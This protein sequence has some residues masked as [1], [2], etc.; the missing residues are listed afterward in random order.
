[1]Y[2]GPRDYRVHRPRDETNTSIKFR[3]R[4]AHPKIY[5]SPDAHSSFI[6]NHVESLLDKFDTVKPSQPGCAICII[7]DITK[8]WEDA[9][10]KHMDLNAIFFT[11]TR[12]IRQ[13]EPSHPWIWSEML[14]SHEQRDEENRQWRCVDGLYSSHDGL[15]TA[16]SYYRIRSNICALW[17]ALGCGNL[18]MITDLFVVDSPP[19]KSAPATEKGDER[20][21][22]GRNRAYL[23]MAYSTD[24]V[25]LLVPS[26][27]DSK[28]AAMNTFD[29]LQKA[30]EY[31]WPRDCL[32]IGAPTHGSHP[33]AVRPHPL[34]YVLSDFAWAHN[35]RHLDAQVKAM[36]FENMQSP[37]RDTATKMLGLRDDLNFLRAEVG[38]ML[39]YTPPNLVRYF[40]AE[41]A[42]NDSWYRPNETPVNSSQRIADD[43]KALEKF[44]TSSLELLMMSIALGDS[45][46][47]ERDSKRAD[48]LTWLAAVYV[49]LSFVT[50]IFGMNLRELNGSSLP[51]WICL[52]VLGVVLLTTAAMVV[53]FVAW[54][55]FY[56]RSSKNFK[57]SRE[58]EDGIDDANNRHRDF[59]D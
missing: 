3:K 27:W 40:E 39:R 19:P 15:S 51:F 38:N 48:M 5:W 59:A 56:G 46:R 54:A 28:H 21:V 33:L 37:Q 50:G 25:G 7:Q 13:T 34:L 18:L 14:P 6:F 9:I 1:M 35:L 45:Q 52:E 22:R 10:T 43:A 49:P 8:P 31:T 36:G 32:S 55:R 53:I 2:R 17:C 24:R 23:R 16:I 26:L 12:E 41:R 58:T 42:A 57:Q 44:L 47:A 20:K 11:Q 29:F 30:M 4:G